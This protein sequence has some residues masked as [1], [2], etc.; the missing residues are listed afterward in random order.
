[1][2]FSWLLLAGAVLAFGISAAQGGDNGKEVACSDTPFK[3]DVPGFTTKCKDYS[4]ATM[5]T[6]TPSSARIMN[7]NAFSQSEVTFLD[8]VDNHI[9]GTSRVFYHKRSFESDMAQYYS[10]AS[11]SDWAVD[12]AIGGYEVERVSASFD[13]QQP[14]QCVA[15]RKLGTPRYSGVTGLTIGLA[16]SALGRD[17]AYAALKHLAGV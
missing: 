14:M 6:V 1:M 4:E 8:V 10:G 13:K 15:F 9:L 2:K 3:F 11:F 5:N 16:C 12:S 17:H 7:L